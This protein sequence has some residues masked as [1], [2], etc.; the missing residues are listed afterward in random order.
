MSGDMAVIWERIYLQSQVVKE[1]AEKEKL[2]ELIREKSEFVATVSHELRTP[3]SS[4]HGLSELLLDGKIA[5]VEKKNEML[6]LMNRECTRLS[7]L[8]HNILDFGQIERQ[9]KKYNFSDI[10]LREILEETCL[11]L[12]N[13][14]LSL[15][16]K[17]TLELP[18]CPVVI[19]VDTD[20]IK[21]ALLNQVRRTDES[22]RNRTG[23]KD[24]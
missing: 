15:G 7:R 21:Q 13:R 5:D 22:N 4:I 23:I 12:K 1:R 11:I 8:L 3:M 19:C 20:S 17:L 18:D 10:D 24:R 14:L 6:E 9:T 2:D 16:F